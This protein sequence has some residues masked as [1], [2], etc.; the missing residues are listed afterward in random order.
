MCRSWTMAQVSIVRVL[1]N[2]SY[3]TKTACRTE[4]HRFR[5]AAEAPW[6]T[7]GSKMVVQLSGELDLDGSG[8]SEHVGDITDIT[9]RDTF[10]TFAELFNTC[11]E[12]SRA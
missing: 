12:P 2:V 3:R 6:R 7:H 4:K 8:M 11:G 1:W 5:G 10:P 9:Q